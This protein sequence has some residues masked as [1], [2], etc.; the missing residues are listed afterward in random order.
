MA[1]TNADAA[2]DLAIQSIV[3][4]HIQSDAKSERTPPLQG[5]IDLVSGWLSLPD[6]A[7][8]ELTLAAYVANRIPGCPVWLMIVGGP[9]SGKTEP[10][11]SLLTS[12]YI[13]SGATLTEAALLSGTS[14]KD[15]GRNATGGLLR[16]IGNFG[17]LLLKDFTS[18][19]SMKA[20]VFNAV[21]AAF[22][23]IYDGSWTRLL[24]NDG[25]Q[26]LEWTG[27]M[28]LIAAVTSAIDSRHGV[29]TSVGERFL[30]Y[31]LPPVDALK[32]AAQAGAVSGFEK[33][34]HEEIA[35]SV[36]T[37]V[38]GIDYENAPS[39]SQADQ[40]WLI[41]LATLVVTCRS[42]VDR[43]VR[44]HEVELIH[45]PEAPARLMKVLGQMV[46][47]LELIGVSSGRVRQL[48]VKLGID[49]LPPV[50]GLVFNHLTSGAS[51]VDEIAAAIGNYSRSTVLRSLGDLSCHGIVEEVSDARAKARRWKIAAYWKTVYDTATGTAERIQ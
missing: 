14:K 16:Q 19:L 26:T 11:I 48:V 49:C 21:L 18:A 24:G 17:V 45:Q 1:T 27:K 25:G 6:P 47:A 15:I 33:Q 40:E 32:Q 34:M 28:G 2:S 31:R 3:D 44:S 12:P 7:V 23:E 42:T 13:V 8:F 39:L 4:L 36:R 9:S 51:T 30:F 46:R 43:N 5:V 37:F 29:M 20:D 41:P 38:S 22:R 50:R 35:A 10:I